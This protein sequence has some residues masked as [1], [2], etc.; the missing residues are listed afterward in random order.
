MRDEAGQPVVAGGRGIKEV[1]GCMFEHTADNELLMTRHVAALLHPHGMVSANTPLYKVLYAAPVGAFPPAQD[2]VLSASA[3][4]AGAETA[5]PPLPYCCGVFES[6]G[7]FRLADHVL[8]GLELL[9]PS[10]VDVAALASV[11]VCSLFPAGAFGP[12]C[13]G[14]PTEMDETHMQVCSVFS[15]LLVNH[16]YVAITKLECVCLPLLLF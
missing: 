15:A 8:R 16:L 3:H 1:R 7:D 9:L 11:D 6:R 13:E 14:D 4:E 2:P 10:L 5:L 12:R